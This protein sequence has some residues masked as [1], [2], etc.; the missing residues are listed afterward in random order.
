MKYD[1][2]FYDI[3]TNFMRSLQVSLRHTYLFGLKKFYYNISDQ[4]YY[5][6]DLKELNLFLSNE[7]YNKITKKYGIYVFKVDKL[8]DNL[9][10]DYKWY[11]I[12]NYMHYNKI[13]IDVRN[14]IDYIK[15]ISNAFLEYLFKRKNEKDYD[16]QSNYLISF[17][18]TNIFY[19]EPNCLTYRVNDILYENNIKEYNLY[20][21]VQC[22]EIN[23]NK[24]FNIY[25][26]WKKNNYYRIEQEIK[27]FNES[28]ENTTEIKLYKY[29]HDDNKINIIKNSINQSIQI[30]KKNIENEYILFLS[31]NIDKKQESLVDPWL[32]NDPWSK[33]IQP[34]L[35]WRCKSIQENET[36][37]KPETLETQSSSSSISKSEFF[38]P[39]S[40]ACNLKSLEYP[41]SLSTITQNNFHNC[42]TISELS[43]DEYIYYK[44]NFKK[45]PR[46]VIEM[47]NLLETYII[48]FLKPMT[49]YSDQIII[50]IKEYVELNNFDLD[51]LNKVQIDEAHISIVLLQ[52][53][54][55]MKM[56]INN[57]IIDCEN[58][59]IIINIINK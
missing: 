55:I 56:K 14:N 27:I 53:L 50:N 2:K 22:E 33:L 3:I 41:N 44:D 5:S 46:S 43:A 31:K 25:Y 36:N 12:E 47:K 19:N 34:S 26:S 54:K 20:M 48:E 38:T 49:T 16:Y 39:K 40:S 9:V 58:T 7:V 35:R 24:F 8:N 52:K 37:E 45:R 21:T 17:P 57:I 42:D 6:I 18:I 59:F 1:N 23:N 4:K 28:D 32:K 51:K 10:I 13:P 30:E 15:I 11:I 29:P